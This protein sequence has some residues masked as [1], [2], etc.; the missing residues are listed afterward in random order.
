MKKLVLVMFCFAA[1]NSFAQF[2]LGIQAGYNA[3]QFI[4]QGSNQESY[5]LSSINTFQAGLI[6]EQALSKNLFFETGLSYIQKG[7]Y[8]EPTYF[9]LYKGSTTTTKLNYLQLPLDLAY[10]A[11][12]TKD[13]KLIVG[14]GF[15]IAAGI[16]GTEKG[17]DN[18]TGTTTTVDNKV[19]FT[20]SSAYAS[21][22]TSIKPFDLGYNF[23]AGIEWKKFQF[24]ANFSRGFKSII[25]LSGS[26]SFLNQTIGISVAY[27][28]PWK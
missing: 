24:T 3:S 15:Y 14:G 6:A 11:N 17:T 28:V 1:T 23:N 7:G 26:T 12:L 21:N 4:G 18:S 27:L 2:K 19:H 16:S 22:S 5:H 8:K 25:P 13:V 20:N 9:T 10:K